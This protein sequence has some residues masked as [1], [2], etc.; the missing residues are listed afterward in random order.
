MELKEERKI[1]DYGEFED[2]EEEYYDYADDD[3][4]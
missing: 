3:P 4:G 2:S 1:I